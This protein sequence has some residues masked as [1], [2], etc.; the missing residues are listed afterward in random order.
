MISNG[1]DKMINWFRL[2]AFEATKS[3]H[4]ENKREAPATLKIGIADDPRTF[5]H[6][7]GSSRKSSWGSCTRALMKL[8]RLFIPFE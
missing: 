4:I 3:P 7:V 1:R 6:I 8:R 5:F 2:P